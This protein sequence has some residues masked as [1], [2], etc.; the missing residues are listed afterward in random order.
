MATWAEYVLDD[1]DRGRP[2]VPDI[3]TLIRRAELNAIRGFAEQMAQAIEGGYADSLEETGKGGLAHLG[4]DMDTVYQIRKNAAD[5]LRS[6]ASAFRA[7]QEIAEER[8]RNG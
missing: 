6:N 3:A 1:V 4:L 7:V 8:R 5:Y 2:Q